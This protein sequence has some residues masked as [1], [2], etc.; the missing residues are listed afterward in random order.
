MRRLT[1]LLLVLFAMAPR[2][3]HAQQT[4]RDSALALFDQRKIREAYPLLERAVV[5]HPTDIRLH[6]RLA[7]AILNASGSLPDPEARKRERIRARAMFGKA[8]TLGSKDLQVQAMFESIPEDGGGETRFSDVPAIDAAMRRAEAAYGSGEYRTALAEYQK[9]LA[10]DS[11]LYAAALFSGDTYLHTQPID[12]A[13]IWYDRATRIDP[14]RETAWRYWSGT[15][16]KQ[17]RLDEAREKAIEAI[18]AEPYSRV[19]RQPLAVWAQT[20][21]TRVALPRVVL[22]VRDTTAAPPAGWVAYDSVRRSW[23]GSGTTRSAA[24]A[25][26]YPGEPRYRHSLAEELAAMRAAATAGGADPATR[27]IDTLDQAGMLE[28]YI[29]FARATQGIAEDYEAYRVSH[30]ERLKRFWTE[31][32]VGGNYER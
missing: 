14:D 21:R 30:R 5:A 16:L 3:A 15:L 18:V 9:A 11:T 8:L 20:T 12:S 13:F 17:S 6:E 26:A 22:P 2:V 24:F 23:Q 1:A 29:F 32:V 27:H 7:F 31:F 10:L 4:V 25:K 19:S 28:A